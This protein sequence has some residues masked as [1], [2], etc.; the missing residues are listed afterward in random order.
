MRC[1]DGVVDVMGSPQRRLGIASWFLRVIPGCT[2]LKATGFVGK[3]NVDEVSE[4]FT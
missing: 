2:R 1:W 4:R 3:R